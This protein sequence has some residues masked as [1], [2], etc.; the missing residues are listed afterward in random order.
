MQNVIPTVLYVV[1]F[2]EVV[3]MLLIPSSANVMFA[4]DGSAS[5]YVV[6][7]TALGLGFLCLSKGRFAIHKPL[8]VLLLF[9][10]VSSAHG[11]NIVFDSTF[12]PKDPGIWNYKPMFESMVFAMMFFGV[13]A[14]TFDADKIFKAM[15]WIG[16]IYSVYA[17]LQR[18][19]LDQFYA[20]S[21]D[22]HDH[23]SRNPNVG[24]LIGQPVFAAALLAICLPF[25]L[26]E[27]SIW[28]A[29]AI[30]TAIALTGN[31]SAMIAA[32][33]ATLLFYRKTFLLGICAVAIIVWAT[34]T[35][36]LV[37]IFYPSW[38]AWIESSG[39]LFTWKEIVEDFIHP[40][41][42]GVD[43]A[44]ILTGNG[45][46]AFSVLFPFLHH[47]PFFEAHNEYLEAL[48][49]LGIVG[50]GL[51]L[52]AFKS[53]IF[54]SSHPAIF[55]AIMASCLCAFFNP[56]WHNPVLQFFTVF[57]IGMSINF[58]KEILQ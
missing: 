32:G 33:L 31:R 55:A 44:H 6:M 12:T 30:I 29:V 54:R 38:T 10:L 17:I 42:P 48:Y 3:V 16:V 40:K 23:L 47:S 14:M 58:K 20:L 19:G 24:S 21:L 4:G 5:R 51:F 28:K 43:V 36:F 53:L 11:P 7:M 15:A 41:F 1:A 8:C 57:L 35:T 50:F 2:Y 46:G 37:Y 56:V 52:W 27:K 39:R 13:S 45:L 9:I 49:G 26:Q 25:T 22:H 18:F 34:V